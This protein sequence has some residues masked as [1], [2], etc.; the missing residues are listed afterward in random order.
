MR[1]SAE[2]AFALLRVVVRS[3][4]PMNLMEI[5]R[6][7]GL[8]KSTSAR[9]L[10]TLQDLQFVDRDEKSKAYNVGAGFL[11]LS[12]SAI[13]QSRLLRLARPKLERISQETGDSAGLYLRVGTGRVCAD[14]IEGNHSS[15]PFFPKGEPI[16]LLI[17]ASSYAILAF[18]SDEFRQSVYAEEGLKPDD[19]RSVE[20]ELE[21]VRRRR[22]S[23]GTMRRAPEIATLAAPISQN[24]QVIGALTILGHTDR[25]TGSAFTDHVPMLLEACTSLSLALSGS[26]HVNVANRGLAM[27][28]GELG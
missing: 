26:D 21:S 17:G 16:S 28:L 8:D 4:V 15:V 13:K 14:G 1:S 6:E 10:K 12:T 2:K 24:G 20:T 9:L 19:V 5:T 25:L 7:A 3:E 27:D 23:Q 22:Y 11:A 18:Q